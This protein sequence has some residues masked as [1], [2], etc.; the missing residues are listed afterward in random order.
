MRQETFWDRH[1]WLGIIIGI[2]VI[3][4]PFAL[5]D[6]FVI[7][8]AQEGSHMFLKNMD[9]KDLKTHLINNDLYWE[10][11]ES[12]EAQIIGRCS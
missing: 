10:D 5:A 1:S 4:I 6:E 11:H 12:I 3:I 2:F 8:P 9:C 7:L